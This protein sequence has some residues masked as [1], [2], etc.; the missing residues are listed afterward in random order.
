MQMEI[1]K[2]RNQYAVFVGCSRLSRLFKTFEM[3]STDLEHNKGI[4]AYWAQSAGVSVENQRT[5]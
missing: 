2:Y 1:K 5:K 4:Y 3:A